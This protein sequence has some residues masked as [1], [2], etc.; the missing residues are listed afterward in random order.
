MSNWLKARQTQFG[1]YAVIYTLIVLGV[2]VLLNVLATNY[3]KTY[4]ST[5]NKQYSLSDQSLKIARELKKD[6]TITYFDR[7]SGFANAR[8]LLDRYATQ[9]SKISV[10]YVDPEKEPFLAR[11]AGIRQ[12]GVAVVRSGDKREEAKSVTE[13]EVTSAIIRAIKD[14]ERKVCFT[15]GNGEASLDE[16]TPE[17]FSQLKAVMERNNIKP[18]SVNLLE[19]VQV[20]AECTVM[21]VAGPTG[22][23]PANVAQ[24]LK[25]FVEGGGRAMFLMPAPIQFRRETVS[26]NAEI[27]KVLDEWGVKLNGDI[28]LDLS[29]TAQIYGPAVPLA[30]FE[31]SHPIARE[32][33]RSAA[34]MPYSQTMDVTASKGQASVEKLVQSQ[35]DAFSKKADS[36]KGEVAI[37][38][39]KDKKGPFTLAAAGTYKTGKPNNDGR[40]VVFGSSGMAG[41]QY[42]RLFANRDFFLNSLNWL[43]ADEDLISIRPKDPADQRFQLK[44]AQTNL[45]WLVSII[46]IP[47]GVIVAGVSVW[48]RRR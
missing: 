16:M 31:G 20:P 47:L 8:L 23:Y 21:V 48:W 18:Q 9:G 22:D 3:S 30:V 26:D 25:K 40:F 36:I 19:K 5:S 6:V 43:T 27:G 15:T 7:Q 34:A 2:L 29:A 24:A 42:G 35:A 28:V 38:P 39:E 41:D 13:E 12:L 11:E 33:K 37:N 46:F 14:G 44:G 45:L 4:D 10:K 32:L 1:A 17:S